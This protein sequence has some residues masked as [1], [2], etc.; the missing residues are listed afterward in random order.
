MD[1]KT[2]KK[3]ISEVHRRFPEF[4]DSSP[5]VRTRNATQ[6]KS[7]GADQTYLLTFRTSS[8]VKSASGKKSIPRSVRVVV[9]ERGRILKIT[10]S[11]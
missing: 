7:A 9:S 1:D 11:R 5:K 4:S 3:V 10:T 8:K 2:L 6:P